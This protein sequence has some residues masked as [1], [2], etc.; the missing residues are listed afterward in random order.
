MQADTIRRKVASNNLQAMGKNLKFQIS[1]FKALPCKNNLV[2][3]RIRDRKHIVSFYYFLYR[4]PQRV[5]SQR[6]QR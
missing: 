4:K 1:D 5:A 6:V 2:D 3:I